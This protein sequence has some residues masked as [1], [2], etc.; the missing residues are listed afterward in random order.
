M[1]KRI[2]RIQQ[3]DLNKNWASL[4]E[5]DTIDLILKSGAVHHCKLISVHAETILFKDFL[6]NKHTINISDILEIQFDTESEY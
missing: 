4:Q 2:T 6:F 3:I 1:G 5:K